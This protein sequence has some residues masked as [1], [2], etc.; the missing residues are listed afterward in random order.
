[1][2]SASRVTHALLAEPLQALTVKT[3]FK[4]CYELPNAASLSAD[5]DISQSEDGT[6]DRVEAL[7]VRPAHR[8][9]ISHFEIQRIMLGIAQPIG[10]VVNDVSPSPALVHS[11]SDERK[12]L[13][14]ARKRF[15]QSNGD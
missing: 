13:R 4:R 6:H 11:N 8:E 2:A 9:E 15:V 14:Y 5:W 1:M 10:E 7:L 3:L 12:Q